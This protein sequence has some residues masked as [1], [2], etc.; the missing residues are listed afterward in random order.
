M[1]S[2]CSCHF[3]CV[4]LS[5]KNKIFKFVNSLH[6]PHSHPFLS[7]W[8]FM[9][10]GLNRF[11]STVPLN[12]LQ[13]KSQKFTDQDPGTTQPEGNF[14]HFY[15]KFFF[16]FWTLKIF[17]V[18][19]VNSLCKN[20]FLIFFKSKFPVFSLSGKMDFGIPYFP[21]AVATLF[22]FD[23]DKNTVNGRVDTRQNTKFNN[24]FKCSPSKIILNPLIESARGTNL[25]AEPVKT[26]ATWKEH[27]C[28]LMKSN[29]NS[30]RIKLASTKYT[31]KKLWCCHNDFTQFFKI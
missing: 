15:Y 23:V 19:V 28:F 3:P 6:H 24:S 2:L 22:N 21:C 14:I 29:W 25:P 4:F 27:F 18:L 31:N 12:N 13:N 26:S 30:Y 10:Q 1:F 9:V 8:T 5:T 7:K 20:I 16:F 11:T 17:P